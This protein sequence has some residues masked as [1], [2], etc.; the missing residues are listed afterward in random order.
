[1]TNLLDHRHNVEDDSAKM[2]HDIER[3]LINLMTSVTE[4]RP[5]IYERYLSV[6]RFKNFLFVS[7]RIAGGAF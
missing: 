1:M 2:T 4:T 6:K 7:R 5:N 3:L